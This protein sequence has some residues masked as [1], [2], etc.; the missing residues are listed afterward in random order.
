MHHNRYFP[1]EIPPIHDFVDYGANIQKWSTKVS[2]GRI[3]KWSGEVRF[4]ASWTNVWP[5]LQ[6]KKTQILGEIT[7]LKK[8]CS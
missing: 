5:L 7:I 4:W 1:P 2:G 6:A 3:Y 8:G